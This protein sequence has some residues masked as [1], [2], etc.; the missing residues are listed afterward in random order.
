MSVN[1][2][3][4]K[5]GAPHI[6]GID[7]AMEN[8]SV[9]GSEA[10][11]ADINGKAQA[12]ALKDANTVSIGEGLLWWEG[13]G[14]R[15]TQAEEVKMESGAAG[16]NRN[17]LI[18][19]HYTL[20]KATGIQKAEWAAVKG[21]ETSGTAA[22][23]T[24]ES[25]GILTGAA[26]LY[27]PVWRV[28]ITGITPADPVCLLPSHSGMQDRLA[29]LEDPGSWIRADYTTQNPAYW[30]FYNPH[31][32]WNP[33]LRLLVVKIG[34]MRCYNTAR[35]GFP[36]LM[37]TGSVRLSYSG[38]IGNLAEGFNIGS[39]NAFTSD[40]FTKWAAPAGE[41]ISVWGNPSGGDTILF[42]T[43]VIPVPESVTVNVSRS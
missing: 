6:A 36:C 3:E 35:D 22:D 31:V 17:D 32:L 20:D 23:P 12:A 15:T 34:V 18:C 7:L 28:A 8:Q 13:C 30:S 25:T 37:E 24:V 39:K 38:E 5:A 11:L 29:A 9:A 19:M 1:M 4:S 27:L 43:E 33:A 42:P 16:T 2:I 41:G 21:T 10:Y 40:L 14:F 26:D